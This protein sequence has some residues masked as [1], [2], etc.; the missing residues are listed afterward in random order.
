MARASTRARE[1]VIAG[2][3]VSAKDNA[4]EGQQE[5]RVTV[6]VYVSARDQSKRNRKSTSKHCIKRKNKSK[7]QRKSKSK[8]NS[9]S[10]RNGNS[11]SKSKE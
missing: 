7:C 1:R 5:Q 2:R 11:R 3:V 8:S 6:K 4:I 9:K 10:K